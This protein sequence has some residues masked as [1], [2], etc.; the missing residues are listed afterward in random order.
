M[1]HDQLR[2]L[3]R[4]LERCKI[5]DADQIINGM[6]IIKSDREQDQ[7]RRSSCIVSRAFGFLSN[8]PLPKPNE[9]ILDANIDYAARIDGAEDI[10][11]LIA[12]PLE[13][14]WA[15][16]PAEDVAIT[17]GDRIIIYLAVAFE[18]YWA[19][20]IRTYEFQSSMLTDQTSDEAEAFF[21]HILGNIT[22]GKKLS[23]FFDDALGDLGESYREDIEEYGLGQ[24]IGLSLHEYPIIDRSASGCFEKGIC[25]TLHLMS[26]DKGIGP[27]MKGETVLLSKENAEVL[28][29]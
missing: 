24:G 8:S 14:G 20:G 4:S 21:K 19:E 7:I 6:R 28:T 17:A 22:P 11:I 26:N 18:R 12:K 5:I 16:R 29:I 10:R 27:Y 9:I 3:T 2:S 25:F 13:S 23:E 1:P 15:F